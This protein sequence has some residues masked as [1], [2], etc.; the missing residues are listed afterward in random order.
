[1]TFTSLW[2]SVKSRA[3]STVGLSVVVVSGLTV[4]STATG[5]VREVVTGRT[6]GA[7]A[8]TDAFFAAFAVV[9]LVF[10]SSPEA[11]SKAR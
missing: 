6:F 11:Q 2:S 10:F 1:M 9:S 5:F 3:T 8:E 4:I 7:T